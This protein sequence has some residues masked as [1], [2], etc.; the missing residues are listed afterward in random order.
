MKKLI[1]YSLSSILFIILLGCST[2]VS[3]G[4]PRAKGEHPY[5]LHALSDLRAARWLIEHRPGDW[6]QTVD[7][8]EAVKHIDAAIAEI[9]KASIEDGKDIFDHPKV[10]ERLDHMGRLRDA[11]EYLRKA[12]QDVAHDEDNV[13]AQGLQGRSFIHIDAAIQA[14]KR[15]IHS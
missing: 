4:G 9:K 3:A 7:E 13:F 2:S 10:D 5:Y 15:A 6:V 11:V 14:T 8:V 1:S 12:R